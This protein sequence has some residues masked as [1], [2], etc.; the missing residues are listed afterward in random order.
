[1]HADALT[2]CFT[3]RRGARPGEKQPVTA[4]R[5]ALRRETAAAAEPTGLECSEARNGRPCQRL[6]KSGLGAAGAHEGG[7][8]QPYLFKT[9]MIRSGAPVPSAIFMGKAMTANESAGKSS[10]DARFSNT[11][12]LCSNNRTWLWKCVDC[13]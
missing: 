7:V 9:A 2:D 8:G 6:S 11:G 13:P 10:R 4:G 3:R 12:T 1:M 5:T